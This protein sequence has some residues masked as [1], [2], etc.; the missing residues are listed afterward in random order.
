MSPAAVRAGN[1]I[2]EWM[3][4]AGLTT[5]ASIFLCIQTVFQEFWSH[6]LS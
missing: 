6:V 1:L 5:S 4:D 3:E 2:R